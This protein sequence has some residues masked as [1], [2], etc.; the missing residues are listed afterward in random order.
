MPTEYHLRDPWLLAFWPGMG[1]VAISQSYNF[2]A[3][4]GMHLLVEF[5][6][7]EFFDLEQLEVKEP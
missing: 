7:G 5:L 3:K 4:L 1:G 2:M 6:A